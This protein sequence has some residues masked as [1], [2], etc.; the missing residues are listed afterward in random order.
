MIVD[1][2]VTIYSAKTLNNHRVEFISCPAQGLNGSTIRRCVVTGNCICLLLIQCECMSHKASCSR[3]WE[4]KGA[5]KKEARCSS[6]SSG[7]KS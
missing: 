5:K 6:H 3:H 7:K 2:N 4:I 1:L